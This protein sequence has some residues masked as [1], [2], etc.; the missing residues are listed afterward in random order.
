[1]EVLDSASVDLFILTIFTNKIYDG[2]NQI[3]KFKTLHAFLHI[4]FLM[5]NSGKYDKISFTCVLV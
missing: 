2:L 5:M 4:M 3:K 1:M